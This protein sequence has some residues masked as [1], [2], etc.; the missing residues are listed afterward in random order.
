[1]YFSLHVQP[2][3]MYW[4]MNTVSTQVLML[5][6]MHTKP[7][8]TTADVSLHSMSVPGDVG[9]VIR[10]V[11]R[12]QRGSSMRQSIPGFFAAA[13]LLC[14]P[15]LRICLRVIQFAPKHGW[16]ASTVEWSALSRSCMFC[17]SS[18]CSLFSSHMSTSFHT[19]ALASGNLTSPLNSLQ[20]LST[21]SYLPSIVTAS[22]P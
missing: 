20:N 8:V 15:I 10:R 13:F 21:S 22:S 19:A 5:T 12:S 17:A 7:R 1:M 3:S 2:L 4:K 9:Q 16:F 11:C 18:A 6:R 14:R